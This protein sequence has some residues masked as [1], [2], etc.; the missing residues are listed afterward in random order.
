MGTLHSMQA[1]QTANQTHDL[2][3]EIAIYP[4]RNRAY[5]RLIGVAFGCLII[6]VA[7]FFFTLRFSEL[8][9]T[10]RLHGRAM[11]LLHA[12]SLI[13]LLACIPIGATTLFLTAVNWGNHLALFDHGFFLQH[14]LRKRTW[15]WES[16]TRLDTRVTHIKFGGSIVD[17]RIRLI[18]GNPHETLL[19]RN[20]YEEMAALVQ[21]IRTLL[22]PVLSEW[23]IKS[24]NQHKTIKFQKGLVGT[25]QGLD[26]NGDLINW[27][28]INSPII[29]NRKVIL[30]KTQDQEKLFQGNI[31]Q[32]SNLDLLVFLLKGSPG[33]TDQPSS[34]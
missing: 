25:R 14:G 18:L 10:V 9:M 1:N 3:A 20:Q 6:L 13:L 30:Q 8:V 27:K 2:G 17:I 12:P 34:R 28:K 21:K 31:N 33:T 32:I 22:L 23:A 7:I 19:I 15:Y 16:T 11:V 24:L 5:K 26:I 4:T 29:K